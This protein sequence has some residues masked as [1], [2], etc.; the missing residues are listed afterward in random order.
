MHLV[1]RIHVHQVERVVVKQWRGRVVRLQN[2]PRSRPPDLLLIYSCPYTAACEASEEDFGLRKPEEKTRSLCEPGRLELRRE[3]SK[4]REENA[5][6]GAA[7]LTRA[8][9][10]QLHSRAVRVPCAP[11]FAEQKG[12]VGK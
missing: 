8:V 9:P 6:G 7:A 4:P 1:D 3:D 11:F 10:C 2:L 12:G 5:K